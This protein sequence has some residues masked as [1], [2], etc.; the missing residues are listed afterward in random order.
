M[1]IR[2]GYE[3]VYQCAQPTPMILAL[4]VHFTRVSDLVAP[5]HILTNPSVPITPYRDGYGNWRRTWRPP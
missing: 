4:N 5:D 2:V 1:R 3:L